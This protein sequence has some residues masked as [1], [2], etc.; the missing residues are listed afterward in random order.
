MNK[1]LELSKIYENSKV[2]IE[3]EAEMIKLYCQEKK[4]ILEDQS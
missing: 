3:N 2:F 4:N 1:Y